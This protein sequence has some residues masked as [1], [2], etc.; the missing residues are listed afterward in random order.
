MTRLTPAPL[1]HQDEIADFLTGV[2]TR[3]ESH[4]H[5]SMEPGDLDTEKRKKKKQARE[6]RREPSFELERGRPPQASRVPASPS[7]SEVSP[8]L[9]GGHALLAQFTE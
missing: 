7:G 1:S 5:G 8:L 9:D 4:G 3:A 2:L 6:S